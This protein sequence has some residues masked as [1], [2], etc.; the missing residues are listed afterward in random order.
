MSLTDPTRL[1]GNDLQQS[2]AIVRAT[3]QN[4]LGVHGDMEHN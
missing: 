1:H 3:C 4:P 2:R